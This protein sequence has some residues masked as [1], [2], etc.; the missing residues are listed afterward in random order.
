MGPWSGVDAEDF[1]RQGLTKDRRI[2]PIQP[3]IRPV[4]GRTERRVSNMPG[5]GLEP[6]SPLRTTDFKSVA[7]PDFA[8]PARTALLRQQN[9]KSP[10]SAVSPPGQAAEKGEPGS[11]NGSWR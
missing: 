4:R 9:F 7:F 1:F 5:A 3:A 6:A 2:T 8:I 11:A 10:A